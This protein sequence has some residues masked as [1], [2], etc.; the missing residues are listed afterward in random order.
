MVAWRKYAQKAAQRVIDTVMGNGLAQD[1]SEAT[2]TGT[3]SPALAAL[4]RQA[5]AEG[6]VLL[7]NDGTLPLVPTR[8]VAVFGRCQIDWFFMGYGSG[9]SVHPT[10]TVNLLDGLDAA[11]VRYNQV[12]ASTYRAWCASEN[13]EAERGWWGHWPTHHPE[14][15]VSVELAQAAA[16]AAATAV[17]VIGR[18]TGEDLDLPLAPGGYYLSDDEKTLLDTITD[19]FEHVVVVLNTSNVIDLSWIESYGSKLG[20]VLVA[21]Q[22]GMEAGNAVTDVLYGRVCPSGRLACTVARSYAQYP[23]SATFGK[24]RRI[25]YVEDVFVGYRHFETYAPSA[26]QFGFGHGLSYT[27][28]SAEILALKREDLTVT[29]RVR[30]ANTGR[31]AG[32]KTVLLWCEPPQGSVPAPTRVLAAFAKTGLIAPGLYEDI[33]LV[34]NLADIASF[35]KTMGSFVLEAGSYQFDC[36]RTASAIDLPKRMVVQ[37]CEPICL[38][39]DRLRVRILNNLPAELPASGSGTLTFGDVVKGRATLEEFVAR[40]SDNE[41]EALSCGEGAMNS[42]LGAPGNAGAFGGVS[43]ELRARGVP[44]IICA[45]GPS[46][47]RLQRR[48]SLLPCATALACTW[49]TALVEKL[50]ACLGEELRANGVDVLLAP[51]MNIQRNPRCGR[52]FEYFSEDP[53]AT[54]Y[55]A[56]AVVSGLQGAGVSACPKHLACNSQEMRRNTSD[57]RVSERALREVYLRGFQICVR[58]AKPDLIMTSYNKVNGVWAHY[59]YDLATTVLRDEWGYDGVVITDWWMK[60]ARSPEFEDLRNNAYRLRAGVDVLM[61]G[62]M[63]H[64]LN[65]REKPAGISRAELQRTALRVLRLALGHW[66]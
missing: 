57:S 62:S 49:D 5:A 2:S 22:G 29:A 10:Y 6:C 30:I 27:T 37:Q 53:L 4:A 16:Q 9:G 40:L 24:R 12:L 17:V 38:T 41:L 44:A 32:R 48:C 51:G 19:A 8:E 15:P 58:E 39:P 18:C 52:N 13:N 65:V 35:D 63:S 61:P 60:P 50:F 31:V 59:H 36:T 23:S 42:T 1:E 33:D 47:A 25:D 14:M 55:M 56:S 28:F 64:V 3:T 45:D 43:E 34:C 26:I 20:A 21:W 66:G 46:G 7:T 54:G 11:N